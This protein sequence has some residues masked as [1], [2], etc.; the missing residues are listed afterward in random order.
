[1]QRADMMITNA[2]L[3]MRFLIVFF[4][5]Y[6]VAVAPAWSA[7]TISGLSGSVAHGGAITIT[8]TGFGAKSQAAPL[9]WDIASE[10]FVNGTNQN[11]YSGISNGGLLNTA[12]VS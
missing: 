5:I 3:A 11:A 9:V 7:P 6:L 12:M 8:G 10:Q 2:W 4:V 1:M